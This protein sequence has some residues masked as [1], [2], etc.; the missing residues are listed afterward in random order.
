MKNQTTTPSAP[1]KTPLPTDYQI[2]FIVSKMDR[3][4]NTEPRNVAKRLSYWLKTDASLSFHAFVR[5]RLIAMAEKGDLLKIEMP[6]GHPR[7][8]Y[9]IS[10]TS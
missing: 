3:G 5:T 1:G 6:A 2:K 7:Y 10:P 8:S 4:Q 9:K